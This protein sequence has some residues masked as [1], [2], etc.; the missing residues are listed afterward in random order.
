MYCFLAGFFI[1]N[2]SG[3]IAL[4]YYSLVQQN[5]RQN[6]YPK[7]LADLLRNVG[8]RKHVENQELFSDKRQE[9]VLTIPVLC[10]YKTG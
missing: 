7:V 9:A 10:M 8:L 1:T 6:I 3:E 4:Y 2:V 5:I